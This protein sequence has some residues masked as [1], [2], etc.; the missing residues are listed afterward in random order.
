MDSA[1]ASMVPVF[2]RPDALQV[3]A[4]DSDVSGNFEGTNIV[5]S[6]FGGDNFGG[7]NFGDG[8]NNGDGSSS[9]SED[10][11]TVVGSGTIKVNVSEFGT[12]TRFTTYV[13]KDGDVMDLKVSIYNSRGIK[14]KHINILFGT[15]ILDNMV[16][17]SSYYKSDSN[18][19]IMKASGRGGGKSIKKDSKLKDGKIVV[20]NKLEENILALST[21]APSCVIEEGLKQTIEQLSALSGTTTAENIIEEMIKRAPLISLQKVERMLETNPERA[22]PEIGW[23]LMSHVSSPAQNLVDNILKQKCVLTGIF[24]LK[25]MEAFA[26]ESSDRYRWMSFK[27][28]I[29]VQQQVIAQMQSATS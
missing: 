17:I 19:F 25:F 15:D 22:V 27:N 23:V 21:V 6:N 16:A 2:S 13:R 14:P 11:D 10:D 20:K 26:D 24:Q 5:G 9:E 3:A 8:N 28:M 29:K 12:F 18:F 4:I 1:D 7:G